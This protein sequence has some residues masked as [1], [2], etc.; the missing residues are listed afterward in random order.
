LHFLATWKCI[1]SH[2]QLSGDEEG[3]L[4][5][6]TTMAVLAQ[7]QIVAYLKGEGLYSVLRVSV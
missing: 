3:K 7:V 6:R 4:L 5:A 1:L 2:D